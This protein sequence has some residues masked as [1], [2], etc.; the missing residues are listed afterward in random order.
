[1]LLLTPE[2]DGVRFR[3]WDSWRCVFLILLKLLSDV[4]I[5]SG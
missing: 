5:G 4:W 3:R 2:I 1:M